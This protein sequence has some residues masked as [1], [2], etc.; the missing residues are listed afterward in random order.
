[1]Q[2]R[3]FLKKVKAKKD[4][5]KK[6]GLQQNLLQKQ[7]INIEMSET[8]REMLDMLKN[9]NKIQQQNAAVQEDFTEQ[10]ELA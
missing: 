9:T 4:M 1:V 3:A 5:V 10:L 2:A 6:M 7:L 8:D